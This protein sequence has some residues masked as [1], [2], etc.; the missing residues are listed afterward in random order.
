MIIYLPSDTEGERERGAFS[1]PK[2]MWGCL[3]KNA[4]EKWGKQRKTEGG[5][6]KLW[7][8]PRAN[9]SY[10]V[11][12][13]VFRYP[14]NPHNP[15]TTTAV[16]GPWSFSGNINRWNADFVSLQFS[17][18]PNSLKPPPKPCNFGSNMKIFRP[19]K[20]TQLLNPGFLNH[21]CLFPK[22]T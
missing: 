1:F 7:F 4:I 22:K 6:K 3:K 16:F 13:P 21:Q 20:K 2:K 9:Q 18:L 17:V 11:M 12:D 14:F 10:P 8:I 19:K 5:G 15:K